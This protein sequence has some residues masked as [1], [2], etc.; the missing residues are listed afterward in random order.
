MQIVSNGS[1]GDNFIKMS[2]P[3]YW[4]KTKTK[5]KTKNKKTNNIYIINLSS[6]EL[7]QE[8]VYG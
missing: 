7:A 4:K 2:N 1:N 6:A 3:V 8:L 5:K